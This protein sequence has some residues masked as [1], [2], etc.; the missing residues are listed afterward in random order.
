LSGQAEIQL[1]VGQRP[2]YN[3]GLR[4]RLPGYAEG[5]AGFFNF[6]SDEASAKADK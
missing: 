6:P 5:F 3:A 4:N 1:A 2:V